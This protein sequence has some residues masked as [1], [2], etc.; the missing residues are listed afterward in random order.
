MEILKK[1][2]GI[3]LGTYC[4]GAVRSCEQQGANGFGQEE[5]QER[6]VSVLDTF[7]IEGVVVIGGDGSFRGGMELSRR[8]V[9]RDGY[10]RER[11]EQ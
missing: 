5:G 9:A 4:R 3:R 11:I 7:G 6:A 1:C 10:C 2:S 8:G